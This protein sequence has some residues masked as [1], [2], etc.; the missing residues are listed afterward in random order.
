MPKKNE[1]ESKNVNLALNDGFISEGSIKVSVHPEKVEL[2]VE[3]LSDRAVLP[4]FATDG[5]MC[6]D[7][8]VVE[9]NPVTVYSGRAYTFSTGL[10]FQIPEGY[11]MEVYGRSGLGFSNGV[12]LANCTACID[13]DYRKEVKIRLQNDSYEPYTVQ[14]GE[15]VAQARLVKLVPTAI[16]EG[17][18]E[19]TNRG[20]FGSTGKL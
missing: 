16:V 1:V 5:S 19:E 20:G 2:I 13:G 8:H 9:S 10:A 7:L 12:R 4:A 11:G 18:V 17:K 3:R 14:P 15:R 6:F